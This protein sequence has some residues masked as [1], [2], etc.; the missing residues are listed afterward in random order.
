MSRHG[1]LC[2]IKRVRFIFV[3][4]LIVIASGFMS[5]VQVYADTRTGSEITNAVYEQIEL[6]SLVFRLAGHAVFSDEDT[7]YQRSLT[8]A[9]NQFAGHPIVEHTRELTKTRG[10]GFDAPIVFAIHL[11]KIDGQFQFVY[12]AR[13]WEHDDRWTP[14]N[15]REFLALLNDFY[16]TSNFGAFFDEHRPYFEWHSQRLYDELIGQINFDWFYQFGFDSESM[17]IIIRPSGTWGHFGPTFLDT[18]NYAVIAQRA[19]YGDLLLTT[20]HEFAHSFAN[21]VAEA[22][23]EENEVF[24]NFS[25]RAV[26]MRRLPWYGLGITMAREYVTRAYTILYLVENHDKD[27]LSLLIDEFNGGFRNIETV[28][29]MITQHEPMIPWHIFFVSLVDRNMTLATRFA[30]FAFIGVGTTVAVFMLVRENRKSKRGT[31]SS[32]DAEA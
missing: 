7:V 25:H 31:A 12:G 1:F 15:V 21:P 2:T 32:C 5:K 6:I 8:P 19:Y 3:I 18:I 14:E 16:I 17:R 10:I 4:F 20:V 24:R 22:W 13:V 27:L 26:D 11:E 23:Y 30:G 29:A 9:F 28:Y